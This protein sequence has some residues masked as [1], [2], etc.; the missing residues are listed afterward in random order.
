[1][2]TMKVAVMYTP[3]APE[4]LTLESRP[5]PTPRKARSSFG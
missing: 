5:I 4:V 1:M 3:G 2:G